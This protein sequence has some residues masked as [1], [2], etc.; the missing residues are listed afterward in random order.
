MPGLGLLRGRRRWPG[1]EPPFFAEVMTSSDGGWSWTEQRPPSGVLGLGAVDCPSVSRCYATGLALLPP[2]QQTAAH[3]RHSRPASSRSTVAALAARGHCAG[4]RR[5][6]TRSA[7]PKRRPASPLG[8]RTGEDGS[9]DAVVV[10]DQRRSTL[11]RGAACQ[12]LQS[13]ILLNDNLLS[14][15]VELL[16]GGG[17]GLLAT[18][19]GGAHL[20]AARLGLGR[21]AELPKTSAALRRDGRQRRQGLGGSWAP[22][23]GYSSSPVQRRRFSR[24]SLE[25][26]LPL[27]L[28]C[29]SRRDRRARRCRVRR[30][31]CS[32][33][34]E[35]RSW[36]ELIPS[37]PWSPTAGG[38]EA[39]TTYVPWPQQ[40][41]DAPA[42]TAIACP[43]V[44]H[45]ASCSVVGADTE[46]GGLAVECPRCKRRRYSGFTQNAD[47]RAPS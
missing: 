4:A 1:Q 44:R 29:A 18:T 3:E 8:T 36:A 9:S 32:N 14:E 10:T 28:G 26:G 33:A 5:S 17:S 41:G 46:V 31:S 6:Q 35:G 24:D 11:A 12:R 13:G 30:L 7:A 34:T 2:K 39:P 19:D 20:A 22:A 27:R 15:R 21:F 43:S 37:V 25:R 47:F 42:Y 16:G 40:I 23:F 38:F 45:F